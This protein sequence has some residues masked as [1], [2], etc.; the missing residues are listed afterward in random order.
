MCLEIKD[1]YKFVDK[2]QK[3]WPHFF[4][5]FI[6]VFQKLN[7]RVNFTRLINVLNVLILSLIYPGSFVEVTAREP[8]IQ[9]P[10]WFVN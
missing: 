4:H 5:S 8:R 10:E 3:H 1:I 6:N 2:N 7:K 9:Q